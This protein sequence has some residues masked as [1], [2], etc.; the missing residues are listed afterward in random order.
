MLMLPPPMSTAVVTFG[1]FC[2]PFAPESASVASFG[3]TPSASR[4]MPRPVLSWIELFSMFVAVTLLKSTT[5]AALLV[6]SLFW[7][8]VASMTP[9]PG[10][11]DE[12]LPAMTPPEPSM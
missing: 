9:S 4:S 2:R 8:I 3:V 12:T 10:E 6:T 1:K 11:C 5:P 7:M